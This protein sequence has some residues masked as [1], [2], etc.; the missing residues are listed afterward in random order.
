MSIKVYSW[1]ICFG[2]MDSSITHLDRTTQTLARECAKKNN[3]IE[4]VI[5]QLSKY[6]YDF[7]GLQ[8]ATKWNVIY[9]ELIKKYPSYRFTQH[10][11]GP[12]DMITIYDTNRFKLDNV[13]CSE[14]EP[15]RP[16]QILYLTERTTLEKFILINLHAPHYHSSG[17]GKLI[18]FISN[19]LKDAYIN[20]RDNINLPDIEKLRLSDISKYINDNASQ[21]N[22]IILGDFNDEGEKYWSKLRLFNDSDLLIK[23]ITVTSTTEPPKTCCVGSSR[24]RTAIGQDWRFGD[25]ILIDTVKM[26]YIR[27]N[28]IPQDPRFYTKE[29]ITSDHLP[30]YSEIILKQSHSASASASASASTNVIKLK[31]AVASKILRLMVSN[32]DPQQY[33]IISHSHFKGGQIKNGDNI[34]YPNGS[35]NIIQNASGQPVNYVLIALKSNPNIIGYINYDY[36]INVGDAIKLHSKYKQRTLRLRI[37]SDDPNDPANNA[38]KGGI[39]TSADELIFPNGEKHIANDNGKINTY[40]LV[41]KEDDGNIFGYININYLSLPDDSAFNKYL[42]YKQKYL[43]LK[44][45]LASGNNYHLI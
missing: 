29:F 35:V 21:F 38:I 2:C 41:Q 5:K 15:G 31:P 44:N 7:I 42:K 14:F 11:S 25:Y 32:Y 37:T 45:K 3:C 36:L 26:D 16:F 6:Q 20:I 10:K 22:V 8:E 28:V 30:V 12:E 19:N 34:I 43:E 40:V 27:N 23:N 18:H 17:M 13:R 1:N 39:V 4:N 24:I 9:T 33:P